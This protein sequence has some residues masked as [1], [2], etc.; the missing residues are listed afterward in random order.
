MSAREVSPLDGA[1]PVQHHVE[2]A[3]DGTILIADDQPA[4]RRVLAEL[5]ARAG[6]RVEVLGSGAAVLERLTTPLPDLVL[7]D[8][9]MDGISGIEVCR[10]MRAD[11]DT[12]LIPVML[13]TGLASHTLRLDGIAA[14][15]NDFLAKPIDRCELL[16]RIR[17]LLQVKRY[18]DD[19]ESAATVIMTLASMIEARDG[20]GEGHCHRV[21]NYAAAVGHR[22][23]LEDHDVQAL[24]RGGFLHD[25]G[26]LAVPETVRRK[27]TALAPDEYELVKS[28][29]VLGESLVNQ[30]R[31]L[32]PIASIIR[33]HHERRDGSGYPDGLR[34]DAIPLLAQIIGV[35]DVYESMTSP[36]AYRA[37]ATVDEAVATL[38]DH[39]ER[40]WRRRDLVDHLLA[41]VNTCV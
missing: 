7:L 3:V 15:A 26:M 41:V 27:A 35:V 12:R 8:I 9:H 22:L 10:H 40:G 38:H 2:P 31:S 20:F 1:E 34:G 18:T 16:A 5:L 32:R 30:L 17:S 19:L 13:M 29:T 25:I 14:G 21:A 39:V 24:R 28:H 37:P 6:Y 11:A 36:R 4:V 33:S 23:G